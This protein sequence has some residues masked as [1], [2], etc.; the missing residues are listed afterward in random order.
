MNKSLVVAVV[1]DSKKALRIAKAIQEGEINAD[2][3]LV[4]PRQDFE[5]C[6][7]PS[8]EPIHLF[9]E[10]PVDSTA[11]LRNFSKKNNRFSP[12]SRK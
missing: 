2:V 8:C 11:F 1:G 12:W 5:I 10:K 3:V 9:D 4:N 7:S 6:P